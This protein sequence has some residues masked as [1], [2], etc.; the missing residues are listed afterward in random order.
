MMDMEIHRETKR[1]K[2]TSE[3]H[4][5]DDHQPGNNL[6]CLPQEIALDIISR[7]HIK[8]IIQFRFVCRS[9]YKLSFDLDLI[10]LQLSR[11]LENNNISLIFHCDFPLNNQLYFVEFSD[12]DHDKD[13]LRKI[14]TPFSDAMPEFRVVSS[15]NGLLC[16]SNSLFHDGP[17]VYNPF[18]GDY[19]VLPK[20][21]EFQDQEV[22]LGFGIHPDTNEYRVIRIVYYWNMYEICPRM[23][24]R[25]RR[26]FPRSEVSVF[27]QGSENWRFIVADIPYRLD[28]SSGGVLVNGRLH[29]VSVSG[30]N[31]SR[32]AR[33]L[34]SFDL[35]DELFTE[36]PLPESE[37]FIIRLT[38][39]PVVLRGC[40]CLVSPSMT[41]STRNYGCWDIWMMKEYGTKE[42]WEKVFTI[43]AYDVMR[44]RPPAMQ[45]SYMIWRS[46]LCQRF[47]RVLCL[48]KNGDILLQYRWGAL[49]AYNPANGM[50]KE[51][52]FQ[53]MPN[54]FHTIVHVGSLS[55]ANVPPVSGNL[56]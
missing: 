11:A 15:C 30:K 49:V 31:Q 8:S 28:Q 6:E 36:V 54:I 42:S 48:L 41:N 22:V 47:I 46:V 45:R 18:T 34:V 27:C 1:K 16:L 14:H 23:C 12:Q 32:R 9:W 26:N 35:S 4:D 29:W 25:F 40:L 10:N 7:L 5:D 55:Q 51:L 43:G 2:S 53:G 20:S 21:T 38:C 39:C 24:R 37:N 19:K 13:I 3:E 52:K 56:N 17:Y 33:I 50:F 44:F